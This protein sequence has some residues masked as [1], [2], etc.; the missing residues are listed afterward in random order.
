M[1]NRLDGHHSGI[2]PDGPSNIYIY[3]GLS[4]FLSIDIYMSMYMYISGLSARTMEMSSPR[5]ATSVATMTVCCAVL[6]AS[7]DLRRCR[8]CILACSARAGSFSTWWFKCCA[9]NGETWW[10]ENG[11]VGPCDDAQTKP[12]GASW[13]PTL[14]PHHTKPPPPSPPSMYTKVRFLFPLVSSPAAGGPHA[15]PGRCCW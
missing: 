5:A 4:A 15:W 3:I 7:R 12:Q 8:C 1:E 10:D 13:S 14:S 6:K 2:G 9:E 11:L